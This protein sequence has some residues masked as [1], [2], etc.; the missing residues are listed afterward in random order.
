MGMGGVVGGPG[1]GGGS[2][3]SRLLLEGMSNTSAWGEGV[4]RLP[5]GGP[6]RCSVCGFIQVYSWEPRE[7]RAAPGEGGGGRGQRVF[8]RRQGAPCWPGCEG[9]QVCAVRVRSVPSQ[10]VRGSARRGRAVFWGSSGGV[11]RH[12]SGV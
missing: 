10:R 8:S 11:R 1:G 12:F 4:S 7:S 9:S 5:W 2:V 3:G 6:G